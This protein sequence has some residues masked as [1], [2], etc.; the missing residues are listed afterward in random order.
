[1][2]KLL[3]L[4]E[5]ELGGRRMDGKHEEEEMQVDLEAAEINGDQ[6]DEIDKQEGMAPELVHHEQERRGARRRGG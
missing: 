1:M 4:M 2:E 6:E 3:G 5:E